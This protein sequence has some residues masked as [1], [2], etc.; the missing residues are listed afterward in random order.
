MAKQ[1]G[2]TIG[3]VYDLPELVLSEERIRLTVPEG[4]TGTFTFFVSASD[5][6]RIHGLAASDEPRIRLDSADFEGE[7]CR[8]SEPWILPDGSRG[9]ALRGR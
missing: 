3:F 1:E 5:G 9:R 4:E 6:S 2:T 7:N 8:L